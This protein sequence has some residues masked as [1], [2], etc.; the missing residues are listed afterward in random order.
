MPLG[1]LHTVSTVKQAKSW[2][3]GYL[4]EGMHGSQ[5]RD[6]NF[7]LYIPAIV[8][9]AKEHHCR[10]EPGA[11]PFNYGFI[12]CLLMDAAAELCV[13]GILR[14][15]PRTLGIESGAPSMG[16][17]FSLTVRGKTEFTVENHYARRMAEAQMVGGEGIEP[18]TIS[19]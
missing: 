11:M 2:I 13:E 6:H 9:A 3:L 4:H 10:P 5:A 18:P 14:H 8:A 19:V 7:D 17:G 16:T 1:S 15:G 12:A